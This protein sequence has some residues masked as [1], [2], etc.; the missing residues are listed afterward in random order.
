MPP[1]GFNLY[2]LQRFSPIPGSRFV[3]L[4]LKPKYY[5]YPVR[6][7]FSKTFAILQQ[8]LGQLYTSEGSIVAEVTE[9]CNIHYHMWIKCK[10]DIDYLRLQDAW[11][12]IGFV[13][14]TKEV[15]KTEKSILNVNRYMDK[16][17]EERTQLLSGLVH[18]FHFTQERN[19]DIAIA[20]EQENKQIAEANMAHIDDYN[21]SGTLEEHK[22]TYDDDIC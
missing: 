11:R 13:K 7:Q 9:Q 1:V 6:E 4:T 3:T 16:Q 20:R 8:I 10:Y 19:R 21:I 18:S 2:A 5:K 14:V 17:S 15:I 12:P 22:M